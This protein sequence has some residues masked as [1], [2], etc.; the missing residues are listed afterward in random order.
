LASTPR[1]LVCDLTRLAAG[2][3]AAPLA[4][5][6][7]DADVARAARAGTGALGLLLLLERLRAGRGAEACVVA[8]G[9]AVRRGLPTAARATV[10][11]RAPLHGGFAEGLVGGD[12]GRRLARVADALVIEGAL[13]GGGG[14]L[15]IDAEGRA[16]LAHA[17]EL[18]G[19]DPR[20]A[21]AALQAR[22]G[23][24]AT[25][26]VGPAAEH[27]A[28][29]A[30]LASGGAEASYTG[31]GGLG[32]AFAAHGL[33][34]L[35]VQAGEVE[36]APDAALA[37]ALA[38]SPRLLAR[39]ADGT[40]ELAPARA[41]RGELAE[42]EARALYDGA[43][44]AARERTGCA[45]CP[46]PCGWSFARP[47]AGPEPARFGK[48]WG[49]LAPLG[50]ARFEDALELA[51]ACDAAGVDSKEVSAGLRLLAQARSARG[52]LA[53]MRG[54]I[55]DLGRG[56]GEGWA[57][58]GGAAALAR[59]LGAPAG[60]PEE[61]A[62]PERGLAARLG[63]FVSTNGADP[64]RTF[65]FLLEAGGRERIAALLDGVPLPQG[66]LD[67]DLPAAKGRLVW[68]H[69]NLA[70]ALDA[71]GFCAFSAA[72]LLSDGALDLDG[73]AAR[74]DPEAGPRPGRELLERGA[75]LVE[76]RREVARRLGRAQRP[77]P[78]ELAGPGLLPEYERWRALGWAA[79]AGEAAAAPAPPAPQRA[80]GAGGVLLLRSAG[81][82]AR[83]L[84]AELRL[85]LAGPRRLGELLAELGA[86]RGAALVRDGVL[87]AGAYRAGRRL[88]AGDEVLPGDEVDL[89]MAIAGG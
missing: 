63:A 57:L 47:G 39:A 13:A 73:L 86:E 30:S 62:G 18:R 79:A 44:A 38:S 23:P 46:T 70:A 54:W 76:L 48:L 24:A 42:D 78:P 10:A 17:P 34:A 45:G 81:P 4:W 29:V 31:R 66:A 36:P 32:A 67:P 35:V 3:L 37:R 21:H 75:A 89:V 11:A 52:D 85:E 83:R 5:V 84:G 2:E 40:F 59:A 82:L 7:R 74:L 33:K 77:P 20:A 1:V 27:G 60:E 65:P 49:L 15:V 43:R 41:A 88:D 9:D 55:E 69:E 56:A 26:R 6:P 64:M 8:V 58:A 50:L 28:R 14:V 72:G 22:F 71:T 16:A 12:L 53:R 80:A 51:A 25:L 87:L 61:A 19:L 68:W